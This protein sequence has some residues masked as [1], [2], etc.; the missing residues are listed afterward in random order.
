MRCNV[1][2]CAANILRNPTTLRSD[3]ENYDALDVVA[4]AANILRND[5]DSNNGDGTTSF[6][7]ESNDCAVDVC[8]VAA[9]I[10]R[11]P[12]TPR[13]DEEINTL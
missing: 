3:E 12:Q 1:L 8:S 9:N 6:S 4:S 11:S 2:A 7:A 10:L 13:S 5:I